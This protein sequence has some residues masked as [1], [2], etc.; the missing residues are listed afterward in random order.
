MHL[1]QVVDLLGGGGGLGVAVVAAGRVAD[2]VD[3]V[4]H[5]GLPVQVALPARKAHP[6]AGAL[7]GL[8]AAI[9]AMARC[10]LLQT[11]LQMEQG[12]S[13]HNSYP[14]QVWLAPRLS[15]Q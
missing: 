9:S 12:E 7:A 15:R 5:H 6:S 2:E 4:G 1:Q 8:L 11:G 14:A 10:S 13:F 3:R